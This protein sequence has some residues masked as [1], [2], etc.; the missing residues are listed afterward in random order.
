MSRTYRNFRYRQY[1]SERT[2]RG[3][4]KEY[5]MT[6]EEVAKY[7]MEDISFSYIFSNG[8]A[9]YNAY[10][11]KDSKEGKRRIAKYFSD[12]G[13]H[14]FKEPGPHWFRNLT[15]D[16]PNRRKAKAELRKYLLDP[17][18]EV[19]LDAKPPLPYWT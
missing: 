17:E 18:Y 12:S 1:F 2:F 6:A 16:R 4:L 7:D 13:T 10:H 3:I 19:V 15:S 14:N 5:W 9:R 8:S 11:N